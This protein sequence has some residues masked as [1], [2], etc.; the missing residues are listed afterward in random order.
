M[1]RKQKEEKRLL[2]N[3]VID[4]VMYEGLETIE[5]RDGISMS[6]QVR[7]AVA[8]WLKARGIHVD[9]ILKSKRKR[10]AQEGRR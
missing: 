5:E 4:E 1:P 10:S 9:P 7:R 2:F 8:D 6:A 3:F